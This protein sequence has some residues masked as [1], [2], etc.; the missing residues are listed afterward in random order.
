MCSGQ[1][2][3]ANWGI[4]NRLTPR[5]QVIPCLKVSKSHLLVLG[6]VG[7]LV[8]VCVEKFRRLRQE[9]GRNATNRHRQT[10]EDRREKKKKSY[11]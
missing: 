9:G 7:H 11:Q 1:Q 6:V 5:V 8:I 10:F 3:K 2:A 4:G